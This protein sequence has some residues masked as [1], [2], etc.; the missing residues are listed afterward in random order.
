MVFVGDVRNGFQRADPI[1]GQIQTHSVSHHGA[2]RQVSEP[3]VVETEMKEHAIETV[4]D[5]E[6]IRSTDVEGF[7]G[8]V[9]NLAQSFIVLSKQLLFDLLSRTTEATGSKVS[10]QGRNVWDAFIEM[11]RDVEMQFDDEGNHNHKVVLHPTVYEKLAQNPPTPEQQKE[12]DDLISAKKQEFYA[13]K[14]TRRLS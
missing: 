12:M 5:A 10:A 7:V 9:Y 11:V 3:R 13:Q 6:W 2:M 8:Y 1:L 4:M 14:R